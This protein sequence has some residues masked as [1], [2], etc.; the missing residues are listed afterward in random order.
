VPRVSE[1]HLTARRE[2]IL[3]AARRCFLRNGLHNTSMQDLISE[4]G[5]SVGAVYRYFR[6]KNEIINAISQLVAGSLIAGLDELAARDLPL[7]EA[8]GGVL[9]IAEEQTGPDGNFRLVLQVWGQAVLDPAIGAIIRERYREL[10][11][12]FR[13][14]AEQA[15]ARGELPPETDPD[16]M[17]AV[18]FGMLPGYGLQRQL[19]GDVDKET[20]LA[21]LRTLIS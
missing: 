21:G 14:L 18:L 15:M 12:P 20:Y 3:A 11:Q 10:R 8:M 4:A 9:D 16:A 13:R 2:Q 7:I 19:V 17:A 5:L 1:D 6:S